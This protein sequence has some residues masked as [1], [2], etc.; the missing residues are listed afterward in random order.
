MN[1]PAQ[2]SLPVQLPDGETF[3][4]FYPGENVQL[5]TA[6]KN[7]AIGDGDP[8]IYL[9]G[10]RSSGT[11]HLLHATCTECTDADRSAAYLPMEMSVMMSPSVLDGMEHLDV[12]CIDN[13]EMIAGISEWEIALF[14]FYNRWRDSH[15]QLDQ[16]SLIVTGNSAA[17]HL[18]IELPDLLSRLD[19]G[20]SYQLQLLDDDAKLAALQ[21]RAEFR[22]LKLP[23]DVGRFLLNRSSRDM[24]ALIAILNTLDSAS[25]SAQRRLTI[26][27][28]KETLS[29]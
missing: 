13:I 17:R 21:L 10:H 25:I 9:F 19:W 7:A 5:L 24:K 4:S 29:L 11:S 15:N 8:F 26:P 18:G 20:V 16:G 28:V 22:G 23:V 27:F 1:A 14:N 2:L 12:V 3:S 6:L